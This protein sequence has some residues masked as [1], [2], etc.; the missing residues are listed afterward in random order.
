MEFKSNDKYYYGEYWVPIMGEILHI[1]M[2]DQVKPGKVLKIIDKKFNLEMSSRNADS[3]QGCACPS[4]SKDNPGI[5]IYLSKNVSLDT[6]VHEITH[7]VQFILES[8]GFY[9]EGALNEARE[10]NSSL[11][12]IEAY[13]IGEIT[14]DLF[15]HL[16]SLITLRP[17]VNRSPM[18][19]EEDEHTLTLASS[20]NNS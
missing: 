19:I 14:S 10:L 2:P 6:L 20:E 1:Y 3:L 4:Y 18:Y 15:Y 11:K 5:I 7:V 17:Y 13:L 8:R 16:R 12:E 9:D